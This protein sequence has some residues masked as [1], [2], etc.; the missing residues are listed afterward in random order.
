MQNYQD[1]CQ[2]YY[3]KSYFNTGNPTSMLILSMQKTKIINTT[4]EKKKPK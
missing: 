2:K 1:F 4:K 3:R